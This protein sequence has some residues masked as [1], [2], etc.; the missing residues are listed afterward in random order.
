MN[1]GLFVQ[2]IM[3]ATERRRDGSTG[4][5]APGMVEVRLML[6]GLVAANRGDGYCRE[7]VMISE[8][9]PRRIL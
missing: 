4:A 3:G 2:S 5:A 7:P 1:T 8:T 9:G 6:E